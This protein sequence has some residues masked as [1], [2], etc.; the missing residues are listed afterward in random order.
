MRIELEA[1]QLAVI[2]ATMVL[3]YTK[4]ENDGSHELAT[5]QRDATNAF[6]SGS[7]LV[8]PFGDPLPS[9][10]LRKPNWGTI[11]PEQLISRLEAMAA[12]NGAA[13]FY[14]EN[15]IYDSVALNNGYQ[16]GID[17]ALDAVYGVRVCQ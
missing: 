17:A 9:N 7:A 5:Q 6:V 16:L 14:Q 8:L 11:A 1:D 3:G 13:M 10:R 2:V 15:A 4:S 12:V